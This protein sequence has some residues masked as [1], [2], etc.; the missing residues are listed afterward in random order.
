MAAI[1]RIIAIVLRHMLLLPKNFSRW[2]D[3][4]FWPILDLLLWGFT[5]IY[6]NSHG[7]QGINFVMLFLGALISWDILFRAQQSI[8]VTFLEDIWARNMLNLFVSPLSPLEF[9]SGAIIYGMLKHTVTMTFLVLLAFWLYSYNYLTLGFYLVP[10]VFNLLLFGWV[11]GIVATAIIVRFGQAAEI[12]A[13][14][15]AFMIQPFVGVFYPIS[16]MPPIFRAVS[17]ALPPTYIFEQMRSI[18][19]NKTVNVNYLWIAF[20]LNIGYLLMAFVFFSYI[21]KTVKIK[22]YLTKLETQ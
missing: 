3:M 7:T 19:L 18:V 4:F 10:A 14:G 5:T 11:I 17:Y 20:A 2:I 1:K 9:L 8:T 15:L 12:V 13:W 16:T 6:L 22:G 21:W